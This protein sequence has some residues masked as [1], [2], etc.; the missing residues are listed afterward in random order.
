MDI[1][2]NFPIDVKITDNVKMFVGG[3]HCQSIRWQAKAQLK[4]NK[5]KVIKCNCSFCYMKQNICVIINSKDFTLIKGCEMLTTYKFSTKIAEHKF[6]KICGVQS[7]Y[8][9]RSHPN[10]I[11]LNIHTIDN[12]CEFKYDIVEFDGVN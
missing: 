4:D 11:G 6:C 10:S 3:C 12:F 1:K 5:A 9:P 8:H 7:F 2:S